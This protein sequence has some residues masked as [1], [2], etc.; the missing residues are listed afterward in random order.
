M[1]ELENRV[2]RAERAAVVAV[3]MAFGVSGAAAAMWLMQP[4]E[5]PQAVSVR[6][7]QFVLINEAGEPRGTWEVGPQ[8]AFLSVVGNDETSR[9]VIVAMDDGPAVLLYDRNETMRARMAMG[10]EQVSIDV[11]DAAGNQRAVMSSIGPTGVI[12]VSDGEAGSAT[13]TAVPG[14]RM[15]VVSDDAGAPAVQVGFDQGEAVFGVQE[16]E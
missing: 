9:A 10:D 13:L 2:R 3:L 5:E 16:G 12:G 6:A 1:E 7:E 14:Q 15:L 8:G 11:W 4:A